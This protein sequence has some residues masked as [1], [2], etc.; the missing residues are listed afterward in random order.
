M[1][2]PSAISQDK[3]EWDWHLKLSQNGHRRDSRRRDAARCALISGGARTA[4]Y[5]THIIS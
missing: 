2:V 3:E 5:K 4:L 1:I